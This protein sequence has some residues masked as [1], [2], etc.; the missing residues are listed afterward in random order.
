VTSKE[1]NVIGIDDE[2]FISM[3]DEDGEMKEDLQPPKWPDKL[4]TELKDAIAAAEEAGTTVVVRVIGAMGKEQITS[5][6][7]VEG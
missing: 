6:K 5:F 1:Y 7:V 2:E 4:D 3:M